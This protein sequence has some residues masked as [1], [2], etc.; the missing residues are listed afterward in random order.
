MSLRELDYLSS[1]EGGNA[2]AVLF[3]AGQALANKTDIETPEQLDD[4][5]RDVLED[6]KELYNGQEDKGQLLFTAI[7]DIFYTT[8]VSQTALEAASQSVDWS[9]DFIPKM[10]GGLLQAAAHFNIVNEANP[11]VKHPPLNKRNFLRLANLMYDMA[12]IQYRNMR[13]IK[14]DSPGKFQ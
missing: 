11:N 9:G 5:L 13:V 1:K 8:V 2:L 3:T 7:D 14:G 12:V 6:N 4:L 10:T